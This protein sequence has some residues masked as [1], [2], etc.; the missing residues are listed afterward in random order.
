LE[1]Y[2]FGGFDKS[3]ENHERIW[4]A[5]SEDPRL[6]NLRTEVTM[7]MVNGEYDHEYTG[8]R[9]FPLCTLTMDSLP[10]CTVFGN[11]QEYNEY[12][13]GS[14]SAIDYGWPVYIAQQ[15]QRNH[16]IRMANYAAQIGDR[17]AHLVNMY[18]DPP[19]WYS[20]YCTELS[21]NSLLNHEIRL[22]KEM[23]KGT[24][25]MHIC[26]SKI[27][28]HRRNFEAKSGP[29][30]YPPREYRMMTR[31]HAHV[32]NIPWIMDDVYLCSGEQHTNK[33]G[34]PPDWVVLPEGDSGSPNADIK[35]STRLPI[36]E[37]CLH[38]DTSCSGNGQSGECTD[39]PGE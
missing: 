35:I 24:M 15:C 38:M 18:A 2:A 8:K 21:I 30:Y 33:W 3:V 11:Q 29:Y 5:F 32:L 10:P 20:H 13:A 25:S 7:R 26:M 36:P 9:T 17:T 14:L 12:E 23:T 1:I 27:G 34:G 39:S 22:I 31:L 4:Q 37:G 28:T 16:G 19:Y 6:S